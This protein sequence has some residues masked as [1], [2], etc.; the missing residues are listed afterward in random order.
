M[1]ERREPRLQ[2]RGAHPPGED[3]PHHHPVRLPDPAGRHRRL[4]RALL[5][6]LFRLRLRLRSVRETTIESS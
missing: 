2:L 4:P 6:R 5:R 1:P 3:L